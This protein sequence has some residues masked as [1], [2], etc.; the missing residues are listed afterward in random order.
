ML[1]I[2]GTLKAHLTM[3]NMSQKE[4][5]KKLSLNQRTISNYCNDI[6]FPDLDTLSKICRTLHIDLNKVLEIYDS[7]EQELYIQNDK[8]MK[9]IYAFR[10][11]SKN[12][13]KDFMDSMVKLASLCED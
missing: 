11:V 2:G 7:N 9:L 13:G 1:K 5:A 3:Q 8:E 12:K 4:L 10:K 6:S